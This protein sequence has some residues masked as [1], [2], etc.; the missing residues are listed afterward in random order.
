M[1][2]YDVHALTP[3]DFD[4]LLALEDQLFGAKGEK[5]LG[6]YYVRLCCDFYGDT[7]FIARAEGL[8]VGYILSFVR[9]REAYC[10]TLAIV[11]EYQR[12]RVV[13][14]LVTAFIA[15][16]AYRV[17]SLWFTVEERNTDA[18]A[19]HATLGAREIETRPAYFGADEPRILSR[20][21]R[22]A[23]DKLRARMERL[24]LLDRPQPQAA[25][26]A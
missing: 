14:R 26:V 21:D 11:P 10:S 5:T 23:F 2:D 17:D 13:H 8:P 20:I 16:I 18:R 25:S 3:A 19:L 7:S 22:P 4:D 12:T 6:P 9:D 15:S 24:G 1:S